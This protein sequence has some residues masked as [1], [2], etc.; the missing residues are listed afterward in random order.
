MS[1]GAEARLAGFGYGIHLN[2]ADRLVA[3]RFDD[4]RPGQQQGPG[5]WPQMVRLET[6]GDDAVPFTNQGESRRTAR[7]IQQSTNDSALNMPAVKGQ[8]GQQG[9]LDIR[10]SGREVPDTQAE[11]LPCGHGL[12][13]AGRNG[14]KI[15]LPCLETG[16]G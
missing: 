12:Q 7:D 14:C 16:Q 4:A 3:P 10:L 9:H 1:C 6:Q 13:K 8:A 11:R 15:S 5:R 2:Q